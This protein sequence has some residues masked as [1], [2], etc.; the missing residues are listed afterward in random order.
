MEN[1]SQNLTLPYG[2][3]RCVVAMGNGHNWDVSMMS[4]EIYLAFYIPLFDI[5]SCSKEL[6]AFGD[7]LSIKRF[8]L[9]MI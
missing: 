5:F 3:V 4:V 1:V 7:W 8:W 9:V 2:S 6:F